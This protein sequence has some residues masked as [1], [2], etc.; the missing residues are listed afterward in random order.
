MYG[1]Y[2]LKDNPA[3]ATDEF[4]REI[5]L[6][7]SHDVARIQLVLEFLHT[8]DYEQGLKYAKEAIALAPQSFVAHVHEML[9]NYQKPA[10]LQGA[11]PAFAL[12]LLLSTRPATSQENEVKAN[13]RSGA[14]AMGKPRE[15][16]P[17]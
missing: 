12:I 4:R 9:L 10:R 15:M 7:T 5:E 14:E 2:L 8:A 1:V 13:L 6:S 11:V 17:K 16:G 3:L